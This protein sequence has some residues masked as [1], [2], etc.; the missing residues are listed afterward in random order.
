MPRTPTWTLNRIHQAKTQNKTTLNL[1]PGYQ[2]PKLTHIPPELFELTQLQKLDVRGNA[3]NLLPSTIKTLPALQAIDLRGN[4][5]QQIADIPGLILDFA[6]WQEREAT[7]SPAHIKG[8]QLKLKTGSPSPPHCSPY[9]I[10]F[11][12]TSVT[13]NSANYRPSSGS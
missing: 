8:L 11:Y 3:L 1:R 10:S 12:F 9:P 4:P 6:T 7:L 13:T 5:L 2:D